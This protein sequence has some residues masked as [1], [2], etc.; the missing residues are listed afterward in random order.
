MLG[1]VTDVWTDDLRYR[2]SR[3]KARLK[4]MVDDIGADGM[5][6]RVEARLGRKLADYHAARRS[7]VAPADHI[8]IHAQKQDGP[9]PTSACRCTSGLISG[10]QMIAVADLAESLGGDV[11]VTRQQNFIVDGVPNEQVDDVVAQIAEIGFPLDDQPHPRRLDRLHRRAAL[12]LLGR[13]RPRR[14]SAR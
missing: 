7:T 14:G 9:R 13:P 11:R 1:A 6:E 4:F 2:V 12:Q 3:V 8:G 10:D 5:R